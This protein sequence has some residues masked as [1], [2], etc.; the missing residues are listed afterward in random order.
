MLN[1]VS[2]FLTITCYKLTNL[3][4]GLI[5]PYLKRIILELKNLKRWSYFLVYL[6]M[7]LSKYLCLLLLNQ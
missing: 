7:S 6:F 3:K 2:Y 5:I 1:L 4:E